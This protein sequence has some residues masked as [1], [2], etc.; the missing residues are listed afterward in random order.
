MAV[1]AAARASTVPGHMIVTCSAGDV[2]P[3][4]ALLLSGS[5]RRMA[6]PLSLSYIARTPFTLP[7]NP[8]GFQRHA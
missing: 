2:I 4:V 6:D 1:D 8:P 3:E 5:Y 7:D